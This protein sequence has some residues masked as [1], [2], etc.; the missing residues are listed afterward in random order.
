[1]AA[2]CL[3]RARRGRSR[4]SRAGTARLRTI[5]R[6][7]RGN[8]PMS[9]KKA[10]TGRMLKSSN[11]SQ[12][13]EARSMN[14]RHPLAIPDGQSTEDQRKLAIDKVG[15]K[16]IRHPVRIAERGGGTQHTIATFNMYVGLPHQFKGTHMSR[17][18][19]ILNAHEREISVDTFKLM[20]GEMVDRLEAQ[21][22]HIEMHFPYFVNK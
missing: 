14:T 16:A 15:I 21:S 2:A 9:L 10:G 11:L 22:G 6:R 4:R 12:R 7:R 3:H 19:E 17:F 20:L 13:R 5:P 1:G 18:V 8:G